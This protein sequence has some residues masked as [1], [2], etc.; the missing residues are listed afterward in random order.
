ADS[1][2]D[3]FVFFTMKLPQQY[4]LRSDCL[5]A[6]QSNLLGGQVMLSIEDLGQDGE[7]L[8]DGQVTDLKLASTLMHV[9]TSEFDPND[10]ES[11]L[12]RVKFEFTQEHEDSIIAHIKSAASKLDKSMSSLSEVLPQNLQKLDAT[13]E[14]ASAALT[15]MKTVVKD[16]RIEKIMHN[17]TESSS[18]LKLATSK[19]DDSIS[20]ISDLF[21]QELKKIDATLETTHAAIKHMKTVVKD[22]RIDKI[23]RNITETSSNLKLATQEI[24]RAPWKLL[25]KPNRKEY[26]IQALVDSAGTFASG[27]ETLDNTSLRLRR[28]MDEMNVSQ[29]VD[30]ERI[31]AMLTELEDSFNQF[32]KAEQKFWEEL[33]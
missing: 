19:L 27:A 31:D 1:R 3:V 16:E 20:V 17:L 21:Q 23:I 28:L 11:L 24:R 12:G 22:E 6:P 26:R 7:L 18:N 15:K 32:Q 14:A 8:R 5:L 29:D 10:Q 33:E 2:D 4:Q 30:K 13:L 9:L 25:Y